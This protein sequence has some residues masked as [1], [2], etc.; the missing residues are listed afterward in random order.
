MGLSHNDVE[1]KTV[2]WLKTKSDEYLINPSG[3]PS[4]LLAMSGGKYWPDK[5]FVML[6]CFMKCP[7]MHV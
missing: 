3:I 7:I 5:H 2:N 1:D 4:C 6:H